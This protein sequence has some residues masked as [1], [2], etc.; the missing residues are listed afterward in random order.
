MRHRLLHNL[1]RRL[2]YN[3]NK[4]INE[5]D[6]KYIIVPLLC[7][8]VKRSGLPRRPMLL[9]LCQGAIPW[10]M[11]LGRRIT[12]KYLPV[13][14]LQSVT[15]INTQDRGLPIPPY[16][17]GFDFFLLVNVIQKFQNTVVKAF[18]IGDYIRS[19]EDRG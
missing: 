17:K 10:D 18:R 16:E 5:S 13:F 4:I 3:Y 7:A 9:D 19:G 1:L 12:R 14:V 15:R 2:L 6:I 11:T 8:V